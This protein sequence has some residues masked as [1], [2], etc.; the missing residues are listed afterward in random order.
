MNQLALHRPTVSAFIVC[1]NEERQIRRCLDSIKWCDEIVVIDSGS[2]DRTLE[3][4]REYTDRIVNRPWPGFVEQKRF[5]LLQCT[6]DWVL[7]IDAD[8]VVTDELRD[9]IQA[10]LMAPGGHQGFYLLRVVH[11][12]GK[13]WRKGGWYPEYRLRLCLRTATT[14]GGDDPHEKAIV[15]GPTR[16]LRGELHHFTYEDFSNQIRSLNNFATAAAD[17]LW[18]KGVRPSLLK[19][20]LNPLARFVKFYLLRKG[21]REGMSGF[22]VAGIEAFYV[23][24]KYV[25]LWERSQRR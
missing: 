10:T 15:S 16:R 20:L 21:F 9:E 2:T 8:E 5:G 24:L 11:Y 17:T 4:C 19:I 7:N 14:W 6:S 12:L 22:L 25:K 23:Y 3:I 18:K 1:M 13:F